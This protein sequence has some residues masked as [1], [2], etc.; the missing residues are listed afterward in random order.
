MECGFADIKVLDAK[1]RYHVLLP[2]IRSNATQAD[3]TT[4]YNAIANSKKKIKKLLY[5]LLINI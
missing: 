5:I 3:N 2:E 4:D 1:G